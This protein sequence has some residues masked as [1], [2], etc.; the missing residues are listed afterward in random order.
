VENLQS[1][2]FCLLAA[3]YLGKAAKVPPEFAQK[4]SKQFFGNSK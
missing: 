2:K 3:E 1:G 4:Y